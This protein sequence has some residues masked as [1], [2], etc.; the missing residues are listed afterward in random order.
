MDVQINRY[1]RLLCNYLFAHFAKQELWT[2]Q[3][4]AELRICR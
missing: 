4:V 2:D 3:N 1:F